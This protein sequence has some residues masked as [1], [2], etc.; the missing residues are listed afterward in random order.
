MRIPF[1]V[2]PVA[3]LGWIF[4]LISMRHTDRETCAHFWWAE[5]AM[6]CRR[7]HVYDDPKSVMDYTQPTEKCV[8]RPEFSCA[9]ISSYYLISMEK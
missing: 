9:F 1:N 6:G 4:T 7:L 8:G 2:Y 5:T 3:P